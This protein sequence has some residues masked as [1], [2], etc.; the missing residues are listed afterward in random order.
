MRDIF[1]IFY[2][3]FQVIKRTCLWDMFRCMSLWIE[4]AKKNRY[5]IAYSQ[6]TRMNL[7]SFRKNSLYSQKERPNDIT[8]NCRAPD[9]Y[10]SRYHKAVIQQILAD[11]RCA[12]T[13]KVDGG[14]IARIKTEKEIR[15]ACGDHSYQEVYRNP[16]RKT[17]RH[18]DKQC[19][20]LALH[21]CGNN[22]HG[23]CKKPRELADH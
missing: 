22:K 8:N 20:R 14:K 12:G 5:K 3:S 16:E 6:T 9:A 4:I 18:H 2:S 21:K 15:V 23:D 17:N 1:F 7:L 11:V 10:Q 19:R 13:V